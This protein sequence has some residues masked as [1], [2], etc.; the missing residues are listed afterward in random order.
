M[1]SIYQKCVYLYVDASVFTGRF[2]CVNASGQGIAQ[3][4][5]HELG[6]LVLRM[7]VVHV[8][9]IKFV[10][11]GPQ[12]LHMDH[13]DDLEESCRHGHTDFLV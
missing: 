5:C 8:G 7:F 4:D 2:I 1:L 10:S 9:S 12:G 3:S 11:D 6:Y 13:E